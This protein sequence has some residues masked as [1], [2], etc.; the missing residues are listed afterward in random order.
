M[1]RH[2]KLFTAAAVL[3]AGK[4]TRYFRRNWRQIAMRRG[5]L[6]PETRPIQSGNGKDRVAAA[7]NDSFPASD[8]PSFQPTTA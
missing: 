3:L 2:H 4:A 1:R 7:S 6:Q 5:M 8:A